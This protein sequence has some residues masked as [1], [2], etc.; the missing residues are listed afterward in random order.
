MNALR[1]LASIGLVAAALAASAPAVAQPAVAPVPS[2]CATPGGDGAAAITF[3]HLGRAVTTR[4]KIV[5]LAIG[6]S[7][8]G[9]TGMGGDYYQLVERFLESTFRG[10]DVVLVQRGISGELARDGADRIRLEAARSSPDVVFWQVGTAD[11]MAGIDPAETREI[12][13]STIRWLHDHQI[14]VVLIG[15]HYTPRLSGD[16]E[17]QAMRA[18]IAEVARSE[19]V[20]RIR[21]Y[22]VGETL[23]RLRR[24]PNEAATSVDLGDIGN[25]CMAEHLA[26]ALATGLF[27]RRRPGDLD[28]PP[29]S[30][31]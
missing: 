19:G 18:A 22:E 30:A 7:V 8:V 1:R 27:A 11:A 4:Q 13:R 9:K 25:T 28:K 10:L 14:D 15:L 5:V 24:P 6:S 2:E 26:R 16:P 17:Y 20:L 31:R 12:V 3:P 23:D 29:P 21:R